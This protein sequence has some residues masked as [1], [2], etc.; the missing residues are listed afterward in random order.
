MS[1]NNKAKPSAFVALAS[2]DFRLILIYR[3]CMVISFQ[4]TATVISWCVYELIPDPL[5]LG[6][7]GL[8]EVI[9]AMSVTLFAGHIADTKNR[10]R[11]ILYALILVS[12]TSFFLLF[13][14]SEAGKKLIPRTVW[15]L[16]TVIFLTGLARGF[17]FPALTALWAQTVRK[18]DYANAAAWNSTAW[19]TA[20][21]VGPALGG[22][23]YKTGGAQ[24]AYQ[25]AAF[26]VFISFI[27]ILLVKSGK[28]HPAQHREPMKESIKA[29]IKFV[30]RNK[31]IL[32]ALSLDMFAVLFGG[33]V[34]LLPL[35]AKEIL[36]TGPEGLGLLRSAPAAGAAL[37]AV[38]LIIFSPKRHAGLKLIS[39]VI[40]FGFCM[41]AFAISHNFILSLVILAASGAFD[42]VSVV[43][44]A[45]ILQTFT[46]DAM[47]GRVS[48]VNSLFIGSSNE[49]GAFESGVTAR[50]MGLVPAVI[51]GGCMTVLTGLAVAF[52]VP[53]LRK[54]S[55]EPESKN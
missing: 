30:F 5:Y 51:F 39:A 23:A 8:A 45:T 41:I 31:I 34:A 55:F 48:S 29:G 27:T 44:R 26:L 17:L 42:N 52:K 36:K 18:E 47:R 10:K 33:A 25:I 21:V 28:V 32:G 46:P 40:M 4:M 1:L 54:L 14:E 2:F 20:A 16:Y 6:L 3:L 19:Q 9:P 38:V 24:F 49:I 12:F 13:Y 11:I 37:M 22:L 7:I 35:F 53:S 43:L 50:L 15:P